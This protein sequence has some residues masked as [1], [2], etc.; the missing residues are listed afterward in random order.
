[1]KPVESKA[2]SSVKMH[3]S[4]S[5]LIYT[6][7]QNLLKKCNCCIIFIQ[8]AYKLIKKLRNVRGS[9]TQPCMTPLSNIMY[10][11]NIA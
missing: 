2:E 7:V 4:L 1:M 8:D 9:K 3:M 5:S 11:S 10:R 6:V